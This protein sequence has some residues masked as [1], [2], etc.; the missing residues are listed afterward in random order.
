MAGTGD[1]TPTASSSSTAVPRWEPGPSK[2]SNL[3]LLRSD[4]YPLWR[5]ET[6]IHLEIVDVWGVVSGLEPQ[7]LVDHHHFN[8]KRA[9]NQA[10]SLLIQLV[11]DEFKGIIGNHPDSADAWKVIEDTLDRRSDRGHRAFSLTANQ[12]SALWR[13]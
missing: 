13:S 1:K 6:L 2:I 10:R 11:S 12:R 9:N 5:L 4:N 7:P 3:F 8:W